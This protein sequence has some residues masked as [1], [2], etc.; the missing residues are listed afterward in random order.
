M[1]NR[2]LVVLGT[3]SQAPT[4]YRNHNG[5]LLRWDTEGLLFDPGEGTQRQMLL[6]GVASRAITRIFI[7]HFHGDHSLGLPGVLQRLNLDACPH[8]VRVY[9]P[10]EDERFYERLRDAMRTQLRETLIDAALD[11]LGD[12]LDEISLAVARRETDPYTAAEGLVAAFRG[13]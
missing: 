1:S 8:P 6:A 10:A 7:T 5:Y 12:K 13:R 2:E 4:R 11:E 9:Y 3:S